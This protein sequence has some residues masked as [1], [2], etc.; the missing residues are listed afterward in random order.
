MLPAMTA[1][2]FAPS[3]DRPIPSETEVVVIGGGVV[4]VSAALVLADL[5][6]PVVLAEKGRIAGEQSS[7]NWGWIRKQSRDVRQ[8]P[9][10]IEAQAMWQ[11]FAE[12]SDTDFGLR[13]NGIAYIA[14]D[15]A[16]LAEHEEWLAGARPYQLDTRMLS[17][18]EVDDHLGQDRRRFLGGMLTPSDMHAEPATAV[19]ALARLAAD[20]GAAIFEETAV[21]TIE[22]SAGRVSGVVTEH[23]PVACKAVILGGGAWTRPFLENLGLSLPQ[24]AVSSQAQRTTPVARFIDGPVGIAGASIR[25]RLDGG[26][27][28]GRSGAA[29]FDI[30]PA[31]FAH[32][33]RFIPTL[34]KHWRIMKPRV[35]R[36]FFGA[37]GRHRWGPDQMSPFETTRV[38][39]PAPDRRLQDDIVRAASEIY[40]QLAGV[41]IVER[42]G[43]MIDVMPDE[44]PVICPARGVEGLVI[45]SGL[46]GHGFGIGPGVG[47]LAAQLATGRGPVTDPSPYSTA[48]FGRG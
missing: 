20:A 24:L 22:R 18:T 23:G 41:E 31:A 32:F 45:A 4:G 6:V 39:E 2:P 5:G 37:L 44:M 11:R 36:E 12:R 35:G 47:L 9:L 38:F 7:R 34:R 8:M 13:R 16:T 26:F 17:A 30:I 25:P 1:L 15:E 42:W 46:S 40:P 27:T 3:S 10:M 28:L 14:N 29:G 19:P 48:R 21:R 43:G 33:R